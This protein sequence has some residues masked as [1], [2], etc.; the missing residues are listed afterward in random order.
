MPEIDIKKICSLP[1]PLLDKE[2]EGGL[3]P[4]HP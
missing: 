3:S 2:G 1:L 4:M